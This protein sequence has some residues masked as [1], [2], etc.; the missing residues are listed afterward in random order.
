MVLNCMPIGRRD[1]WQP[2][3]R[4]PE[5]AFEVEEGKG[6]LKRNRNP[7][8]H[9][10]TNVK[11]SLLKSYYN[12]SVDSNPSSWTPVK[13]TDLYHDKSYCQTRYINLTGVRCYAKPLYV[14][15]TAYTRSLCGPQCQH[16]RTTDIY[17][18][19]LR[20]FAMCTLHKNSVLSK[21]EWESRLFFYNYM[22]PISSDLELISLSMMFYYVVIS[23]SM[24]R[25]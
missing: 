3:K 14:C 16:Y 4:V 18:L 22:L 11:I 25:E 5:Q 23:S 6:L 1:A 24:L 20:Q 10:Y 12:Q 13:R 2:R 9:N 19:C 15:A 8:T 17:Y 7:E 21:P